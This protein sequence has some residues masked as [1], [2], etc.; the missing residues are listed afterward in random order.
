MC[1]LNGVKMLSHIRVS[2]LIAEL[3][4]LGLIDARVISRG[5]YGRTRQIRMSFSPAIA[6][7]MKSVLSEMGVEGI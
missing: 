6:D 4:T 3:D 2:N 5:R 7:R 1:D